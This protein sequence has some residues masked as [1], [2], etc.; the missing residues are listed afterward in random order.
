MMIILITEHLHGFFLFQDS[1]NLLLVRLLVI[2]SCFVLNF[3]RDC[4]V[5]AS[6]FFIFFC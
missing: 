4:Y 3:L 6:D 5:W 2:L 1:F